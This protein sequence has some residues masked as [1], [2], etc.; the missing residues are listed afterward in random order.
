MS[1]TDQ[2]SPRKVMEAVNRGFQRLSNFRNARLM[3][4]RSYVG[5]YYDKARVRSAP[6]R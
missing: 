2:V 1:Y 3:F 6:S 4:L 5:Q